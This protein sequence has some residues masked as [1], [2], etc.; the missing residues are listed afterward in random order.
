MK[1][2][3]VKNFQFLILGYIIISFLSVVVLIIFQF[4][5]LGYS[6]A[7]VSALGY[8]VVFQFLILGYGVPPSAAIWARRIIFQFLI[9]GY[10]RPSSRSA[11]LR[12]SLSIPHFRIQGYKKALELKRI[13]N[14]QFLILGYHSRDGGG[15]LSSQSAF[16]S[17]FQ[18]T[19]RGHTPS[20]PPRRLSIPH[21]RILKKLGAGEATWIKPFNSSFQDTN[22]KLLA[23]STGTYFFQF[24]ILGYN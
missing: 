21:F 7:C 18:D 9:L 2:E 23:C 15:G 3:E 10:Q 13:I 16:N 22:C 17:S 24:L 20:T 8:K 6:K 14:F 11:L 4:L 1:K 5:I 19:R 12:G